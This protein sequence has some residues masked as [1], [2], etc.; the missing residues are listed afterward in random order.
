L[1]WHGRDCVGK[2]KPL[3]G[4]LA[5]VGLKSQEVKSAVFLDGHQHVLPAAHR[6]VEKTTAL[7]RPLI[8]HAPVQIDK[9]SESIREIRKEF[10]WFVDDKPVTQ[11]EFDKTTGNTILQL[12]GRWE[13]NNAVLGDLTTQ[14][15]YELA[16]DYFQ[17]YD[18]MMRKLDLDKV[19]DVSRRLVKPDELTFFVVGDREKILPGLQ[20]LGFQ[21]IIFLDA[22]GTPLSAKA[23]VKP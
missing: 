23:D 11:E 8:A 22:D 20:D 17:Q 21:E 19:Q 3:P 12:P 5:A 18:R 15:K 1:W 2:E 13:T 4:D 10:R 16:D 6:R 9:T 14:I 7:Q